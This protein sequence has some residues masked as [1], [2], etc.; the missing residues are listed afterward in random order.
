MGDEKCR[1][2]E[3]EIEISAPAQ[4]APHDNYP[5]DQAAREGK[6]FGRPQLDGCNSWFCRVRSYQVQ[7]QLFN[8]GTVRQLHMSEHQFTLFHH[9]NWHLC[10]SREIH[11]CTMTPSRTVY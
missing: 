11:T 6:V 5:S 4:T 3:H 10:L 8:E 7:P 2:F 9:S 1:T